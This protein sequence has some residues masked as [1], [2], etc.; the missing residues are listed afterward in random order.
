MSTVADAVH[1]DAESKMQKAIEAT[2]RELASVRTGRANPMVLDRIMVDY[3][4][5]ATPIRQAANVT[6]PDGQTLMIS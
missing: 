4:G 2:Q 5:T 1:Q 3:Y 6:V